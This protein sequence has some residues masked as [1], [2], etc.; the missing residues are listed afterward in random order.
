ME[1][2]DS[3]MSNGSENSG[4]PNEDASMPTDDSNSEDEEAVSLRF[5]FNFNTHCVFFKGIREAG[6]GIG[7]RNC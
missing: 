7:K 5:T 2:E 4:V 6:R 1:D 3:H